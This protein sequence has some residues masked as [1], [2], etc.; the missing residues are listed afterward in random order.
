MNY[1]KALVR[2]DKCFLFFSPFENHS[3][4]Y[5]CKQKILKNYGK[6]EKK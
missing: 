4:P 2:E 1:F 3:K 6:E 5:L